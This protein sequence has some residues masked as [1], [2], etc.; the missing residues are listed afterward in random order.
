MHI[1]N[2]TKA[3]KRIAS[4]HVPD[5]YFRDYLLL[6]EIDSVFYLSIDV[7]TLV[8]DGL[9]LD[10]FDVDDWETSK[11]TLSSQ[12]SRAAFSVAYR[13]ARIYMKGGVIALGGVSRSLLRDLNLSLKLY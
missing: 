1:N 2:E 7:Y 9:G 5:G 6:Q 13:L 12:A 3:L 10:V 8:T 11:V 4:N